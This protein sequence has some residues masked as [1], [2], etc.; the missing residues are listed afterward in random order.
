M[1]INA[2]V[3]YLFIGITKEES[4]FQAYDIL[5]T[6]NQDIDAHEPFYEKIKKFIK[7][8]HFAPIDSPKFNGI[9]EVPLPSSYDSDNQVV[10]VAFLKSKFGTLDL[11]IMDGDVSNE[12]AWWVKI[13]GKIPLIIQGGRGYGET[14]LPISCTNICLTVIP[15]DHNRTGKVGGHVIDKATVDYYSSDDH[16]SY[17]MMYIA[18]G[19]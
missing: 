1:K 14:K 8:Q 2:K 17:D 3:I 16:D 9:P 7:E 6:H 12:K 18:I 5:R 10:N 15:T 4:K 19:V 11:G 13:G